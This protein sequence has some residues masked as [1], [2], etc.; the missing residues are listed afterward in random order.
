MPASDRLLDLNI[1]LTTW[2]SE[3]EAKA[4]TQM[5]MTSLSKVR[6]SRVSGSLMLPLLCLG[7][8]L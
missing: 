8:E 7:L 6:V 5:M 1:D 4:H 3:D 2:V